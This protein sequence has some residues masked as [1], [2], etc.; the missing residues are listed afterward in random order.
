[1]DHQPHAV[2]WLDDQTLYLRFEG[3][4]HSHFFIILQFFK[5]CMPDAVWD[6]DIRTWKL[7]KTS[8]QEVAVFAYQMFGRDSLRLQGYRPPQQLKLPWDQMN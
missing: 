6:S 2:Y 5:E 3:V 8:V 1:M 4:E 7:P